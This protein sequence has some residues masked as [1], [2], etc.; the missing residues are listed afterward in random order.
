MLE[1]KKEKVKRC[2][3]HQKGQSHKDPAIQ[4][5][6]LPMRFYFC[7][8]HL[9]DIFT[10]D[11]SLMSQF[12]RDLFRQMAWGG[13]RY[14]F[15]WQICTTM[16]LILFRESL[17]CIEMVLFHH[18][19][20]TKHSMRCPVENSQDVICPRESMCVP[21]LRCWEHMGRSNSAQITGCSI[22]Q[23]LNWLQVS[24]CLHRVAVMNHVSEQEVLSCSAQFSN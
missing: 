1:Q 21:V 9:C 16:W 15:Y 10:M 12:I 23:P 14:E 18:A 22:T 4:A 5:D 2:T 8:P 20:S 24:R 7:G 11:L 13:G 6:E 19:V 17:Y 3:R